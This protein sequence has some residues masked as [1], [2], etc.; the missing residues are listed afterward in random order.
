M[1]T[2][3]V[4]TNQQNHYSAAWKIDL[5]SPVNGAM[6]EVM[7]S[8]EGGVQN[9]KAELK[10]KQ[11]SELLKTIEKLFSMQSGAS[12]YTIGRHQLAQATHVFHYQKPTSTSHSVMIKTPARTMEGEVKYS[13]SEYSI[14]FHPNKDVSDSKYEVSAKHSRSFWAQESRFQ[15][16]ISHP[17]LGKDLQVDIS[18]GTNGQKITGS[19]ELDIFSRSEDKITGKLESLIYSPNTVII[20]AHLTGKVSLSSCYSICNR[21]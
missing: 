16:H 12:Y 19:V 20:E 9:F 3:F 10:V 17:R 11:I 5:Q 7:M 8:P 18:Y 4:L 6:Y 15:G 13:P 21:I 14:K 2:K 1:Q